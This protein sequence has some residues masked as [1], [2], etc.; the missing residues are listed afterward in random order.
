PDWL[1]ARLA[2][3]A[4]TAPGPRAAFASRPARHARAARGGVFEGGTVGISACMIVR[5]E[6]RLLA[7]CLES[8]RG[9]YDE[10]NIVDTGSK[11][12]TVEI[13]TGFGARLR[14]F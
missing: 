10:L 5:D 9:A 3:S 2:R 13:A 8:F 14:S 7:R 12:R 1:H 6:E 11:D 4:L